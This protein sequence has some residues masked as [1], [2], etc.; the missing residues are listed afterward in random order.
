M[1]YSAIPDELKKLNQWVC[2]RNDSK[3]PFRADCGG[4]ASCSDPSTWTDFK[5]AEG[6]V[7]ADYYDHLG[8]VFNLNGIVGIDIDCGFNGGIL[9]PLAIDV[10]RACESYTEK[11]RS[12][13]GVHI[14]VKGVLP[15]KGKNNLNGVEIYQ[16]G[17]YFI[18][19]GK[20]LVYADLIENQKGIDYV[21]NTY[22]PTAVRTSKG[23]SRKIYRP[24]YPRPSNG[25]IPLRPQYPPIGR[26][27]RNMSLASLAGQ[28]HAQGYD[29][30]VIYR[31]LLYANEQAC[32]PPLPKS[33][34][35]TIV[36]SIT[37]YER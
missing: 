2:A 34:V 33:E 28:L 27:G 19:T 1:N 32:D 10:M 3:L 15:F 36:N 12:G 24:V 20:K 21:V 22:F 17:R 16:T 25:R 13:R 23:F 14:F 7:T 11:S 6:A 31:E 8:F 18:T 35:E 5:T 29:R 9:S 26:G 4:V 37:R 30:D